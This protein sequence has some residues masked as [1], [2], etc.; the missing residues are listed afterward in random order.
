MS[1]ELSQLKTVPEKNGVWCFAYTPYVRLY[2]L[3]SLRATCS[4]ARAMISL[5]QAD[6]AAG[7]M[8][9]A[10]NTLPVYL[11]NRMV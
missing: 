3:R 7:Q 1:S 2:T 9:S 11:H 8:V 10:E 5:A 4:Q 6:W